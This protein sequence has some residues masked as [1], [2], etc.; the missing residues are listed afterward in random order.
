LS[1]L[2][3]PDDPTTSLTNTGNYEEEENTVRKQ[4]PG[5][6]TAREK[7]KD[8]EMEKD[9]IGNGLGMMGTVQQVSDVRKQSPGS[10][11]ATEKDNNNGEG[12]VLF[13][14]LLLYLLLFFSSHENHMFLS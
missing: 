10:I 13:S 2:K 12:I 3:Y 14:V 6:S 1:F 7:Y 11:T 5:L 9:D 4:S 8:I